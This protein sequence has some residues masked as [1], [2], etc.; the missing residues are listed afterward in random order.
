MRDHS[1]ELDSVTARDLVRVVATVMAWGYVLLWL[2]RVGTLRTPQL[3]MLCGLS[4]KLDLIWSITG[5]DLG[6]C[7]RLSNTEPSVHVVSLA[8]RKINCKLCF[9]IYSKIVLEIDKLVCFSDVF[10]TL[11]WL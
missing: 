4:C 9:K 2:L 7:C 1:L 8:D 5:T 6:T 10:S 11:L 3:L